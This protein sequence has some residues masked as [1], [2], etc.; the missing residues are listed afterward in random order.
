VPLPIATRTRR[1][2][3][4]LGVGPPATARHP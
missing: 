2:V 3:N 1:Y 4:S